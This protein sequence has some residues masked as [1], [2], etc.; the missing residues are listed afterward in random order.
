[1]CPEVDFKVGDYCMKVDIA[2][3]QPP[4]SGFGLHCA[5]RKQKERM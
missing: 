2:P 5:A 1:M 4:S 3:P